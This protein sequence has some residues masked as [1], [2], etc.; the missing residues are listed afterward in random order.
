MMLLLVLP[1]AT[2]VPPLAALTLVTAVW[3]VLSHVRA[4]VVASGSSRGTFGD[5]VVRFLT[6]C[7]EARPCRASVPGTALRDR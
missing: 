5:R 6:P 7:F 2:V 4:R 1:L 3:V